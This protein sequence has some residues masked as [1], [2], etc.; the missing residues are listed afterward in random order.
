MVPVL[1][2]GG[3]GQITWVDLV[4]LLLII[5]AYGL[6]WLVKSTWFVWGPLLLVAAIVKVRS[7]ME[8]ER[9]AE[10]TD[11]T[12]V[13]RVSRPTLA[14]GRDE[15]KLQ[16]EPHRVFAQWRGLATQADDGA[17]TVRAAFRKARTIDA[18]QIRDLAWAS[19]S[20]TAGGRWQVL[21]VVTHVGEHVVCS[22]PI[23]DVR[24][25]DRLEREL[26]RVLRLA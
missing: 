12:R 26:R 19:F 24:A 2:C 14:V 16:A 23:R 10:L 18:D 9:R 7:T 13:V 6:F 8:S 5:A 21:E 17:L 3:W 1:A 4:G 22:R 20:R 15:F 25:A 11:F